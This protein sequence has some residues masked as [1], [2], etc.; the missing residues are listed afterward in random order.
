MFQYK[1]QKRIVKK[2]I[3]FLIKEEI[4]NNFSLIASLYNR[5]LNEIVTKSL[6]FELNGGKNLEKW[7]KTR[8][9]MYQAKSEVCSATAFNKKIKQRSKKTKHKQK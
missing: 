5:S 7:K 6:S 4:K 8:K 2:D 9:K 3:H 1:K